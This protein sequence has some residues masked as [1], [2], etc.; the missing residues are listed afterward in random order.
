[1]RIHRCLYSLLFAYSNADN[2]VQNLASNFEFGFCAFDHMH[3]NVYL[4]IET[5]KSMISACNNVAYCR[6]IPYNDFRY[7][8]VS[9][10]GAYNAFN[11]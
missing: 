1:M 3:W 10:P 8:N 2:R 6:R 5:C 7:W 4:A 11:P 9:L